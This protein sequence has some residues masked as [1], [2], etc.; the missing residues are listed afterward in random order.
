MLGKVNDHAG[1]R[2]MQ[3]ADFPTVLNLARLK[4]RAISCFIREN[5][6]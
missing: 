2:I 3:A 4:S 6:L 1:L 5:I